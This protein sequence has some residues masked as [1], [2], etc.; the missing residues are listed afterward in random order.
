MIWLL[1]RQYNCYHQCRRERAAWGLDGR[2]ADRG[3]S[4]QTVLGYCT[5]LL[6]ETLQLFLKLFL[7]WVQLA[8]HSQ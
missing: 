3:S 6:L 2:G 7:E 1:V 8:H 5:T 4:M